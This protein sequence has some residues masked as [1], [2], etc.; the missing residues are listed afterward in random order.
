MKLNNKLFFVF[1]IV[2]ALTLA[3][4]GLIRRSCRHPERKKTGSNQRRPDRKRNGR[5]LDHPREPIP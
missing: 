3:R 4:R 5:R 1:A 2:F